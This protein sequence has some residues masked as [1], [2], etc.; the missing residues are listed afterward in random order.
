MAYVPACMIKISKG[1]NSALPESIFEAISAIDD[2]QKICSVTPSDR[3]LAIKS[4]T[5]VT[6]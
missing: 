4:A 6:F 2:P 1:I 3:W 5:I